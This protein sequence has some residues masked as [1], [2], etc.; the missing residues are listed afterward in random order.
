[1]L[2]PN[3]LGILKRL[4][5]NEPWQRAVG[6]YLVRETQRNFIEEGRPEHWK[7]LK[8]QQN[9]DW[10]LKKG[11]KWK[12][13]KKS[14]FLVKILRASGRLFS[15]I[16]WKATKK[17]TLQVGTNLIYAPTHQFGRTFTLTKPLIVRIR[18]TKYFMLIGPGR[19]EIP[20]RPFLVILPKFV[21][22]IKFMTMGWLFTG[23]ARR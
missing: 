11:Q 2:L 17:W 20:A 18:R 4:Q 21:D 16:V 19:H 15:S 13:V 8:I 12:K 23:R 9:L 7:P 3:A 10:V 14:A 6:T 22:D 1:M 5:R